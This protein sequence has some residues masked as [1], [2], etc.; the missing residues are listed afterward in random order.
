MVSFNGKSQQQQQQRVVNISQVSTEP[1][2][3]ERALNLT[4]SMAEAQFIDYCCQKADQSQDQQG[5]ILWYFIKAN[6]EQDPKEEMLNLLGYKKEDND[7]KF[8]KYL[9]PPEMDNHQSQNNEL[10]ENIEMITNRISN[11]GQQQQQQQVNNTFFHFLSSPSLSF[12]SFP[13]YKC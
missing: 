3:V 9:P 6:F 10:N 11:L 1:N 2:L 8:M 12:A 7:A 4:K 5:R 13:I